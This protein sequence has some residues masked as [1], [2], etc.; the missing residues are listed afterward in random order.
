MPERKRFL[1]KILTGYSQDMS[2]G[3]RGRKVVH[4]IRLSEPMEPELFLA[5]LKNPDDILY[6]VAIK[7]YDRLHSIAAIARDVFVSQ[8]EERLAKIKELF[9]RI[10]EW[11]RYWV[12]EGYPNQKLN[13]ARW[14]KGMRYGKPIDA[15]VVPVQW[16]DGLRKV[17]MIGKEMR[18]KG[19]DCA[20]GK[21]LVGDLLDATEE[22]VAYCRCVEE[23]GDEQ[24]IGWMKGLGIEFQKFPGG[25]S[26]SE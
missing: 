21:K 23:S 14:V 17:M 26:F 22:L 11:N 12:E 7:E 1:P 10:Q 16:Y 20:E 3:S 13:H 9:E 4:D 8:N 2:K 18:K 19:P 6:L 24:L 25:P 5:N 15:C